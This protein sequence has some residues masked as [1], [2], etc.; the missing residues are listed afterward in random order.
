MA[1]MYASDV[2]QR[3]AT[4]AVQIHGA[5][6]ASDEFPVARAYRDA[7]IFQIVEGTN[8][9]HRTVIARELLQKRSSGMTVTAIATYQPVW[10]DG[11]RRVTALD[12]DVVTMAVAVG[13]AVLAG[14]ERPVGRV[15]LVSRDSPV[16]DGL[17]AG[18]VAS[19]TRSRGRVPIE[20]RVGGAPAALEAAAAAEAGT[21]VV[22]V[23]LTGAGRRRRGGRDRWPRRGR[24][25]R[26]WSSR[27]TGSLPMRVQ[28]IGRDHPDVYDDVRVERS[29][30]SAPLLE[31][32]R[33]AAGDLLVAGLT[34]RDASRLGATKDAAPTTGAA[35]ASVPAGAARG[36][37][38]IGAARRRRSGR[39]GRRR[40]AVRS[41]CDASAD[42]TGA[43]CRRAS[44]ALPGAGADPVLD[45]GLRQ[46]VRI[47]DRH[48]RRP[49]R[50]RRT[51]ASRRELSAWP[52]ATYDR[53]TPFAL[54]RTGEVYTVVD[55]HVS[56]PGVPGPYALAIVQLD[57]V[58]IRV[59]AQVAD[60]IHGSCHIGDRGRLVLRVVAER[61][62][63]SGLRVRVGPHRRGGGGRHEVG[64]RRRR[65]DDPVRRALR[66]GDEGHAAAPPARR[67]CSRSTRASS[68]SE[69]QAAW[70]GQLQNV[71][72]AS[73][74]GARRLVRPAGHPG[75]PRREP[76][77]D[78]QRRGAQRDVRH[79]SAARSTSR[80]WSAPTRRGRP[81]TQI[82]VLGLD[83]DW[84]ATRPGTSR[85][86]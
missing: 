52:A 72:R 54:P 10:S 77:R 17:G 61:E 79:R 71:G 34:G 76:V 2:F 67:R 63:V 47:E 80:W 27:T 5:Y 53:T 64:G 26:A 24:R 28:H 22:A 59:L 8:E 46:R 42:P 86:G 45:A 41:C 38:A 70:F 4:E 55:I 19:R 18:V 16:V 25:G 31:Q 1:K 78:R 51:R 43:A 15:V 32:L 35:A 20:F 48:G 73:G 82:D 36:E 56:V 58:P 12:E 62:G 60:S 83:G 65:R 21:V 30:A 3:A 39:R 7:K 74:R 29:F 33:P 75:H 44:G 37:F 23:D 13:R 57:G 9:I 40:R 11:G 85:W 50:V 69:I 6:G 81:P 49:V 68:K 14:S 84:R 66:P